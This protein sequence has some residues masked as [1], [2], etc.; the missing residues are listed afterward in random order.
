MWKIRWNDSKGNRRPYWCI[1]KTVERIS[2]RYYWPDI[3]GVVRKYVNTCLVCQI[4]K[5][6]A[7]QKTSRTMNP[8]PTPP[9]VMPQLGIDLMRMKPTNK[10]DELHNICSGLFHKVLW[11]GCITKQ[12]WTHGHYLDIW[13]H[14]L[15][16]L[17]ILPQY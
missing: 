8:V 7:I 2:S 13:Q 4:G 9:K 1:S 14:I 3:N 16:V 17:L 5:E 11:V 10:E 12:R 15:Q 6:R